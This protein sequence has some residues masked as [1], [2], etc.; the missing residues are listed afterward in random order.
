MFTIIVIF[1]ILVIKYNIICIYQYISFHIHTIQTFIERAINVGDE[2][3]VD[4]G[5]DTDGSE[6]HPSW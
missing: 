3:F 1:L 4:Y 6:W 5:Y 2:I